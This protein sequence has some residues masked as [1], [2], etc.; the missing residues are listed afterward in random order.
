MSEVIT[1]EYQKGGK[2]YCAQFEKSGDNF[3]KIPGT[4]IEIGEV[5]E[6]RVYVPEFIACVCGQSSI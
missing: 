5:V 1:H 4:E 3:F 2:K 6:E